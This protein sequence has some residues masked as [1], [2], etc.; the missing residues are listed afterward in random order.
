MIEM[1]RDTIAVIICFN[2]NHD[3]LRGLI[4]AISGSVGCVVLFNNGGLDPAKL[5]S[6]AAV[7]I[8]VESPGQNLGLATPLNFACEYGAKNGYRF[9]VSFDQDSTP[10]ADMIPLLERE[11]LTYQAKNPRA[12]AI[13]PRLV[14]VRDGKETISPFVRFGKVGVTKWIGEGTEPVSQ[15]ITSGCLL[16]L[17]MW[18]AE[19]RFNDALF[20]DFVDNN[21]CWR[22]TRK[23][24][25]ILGTSRTRMP[26]ELSEEIKESSYI[27]L[28]KYGQIRRYFQMRN[29]AY[30]LVHESLSLAQ[31][32]YVLRAMVVAFLSSMISD[33]QPLQS[34]WQCLRGLAHGLVGRLG[35][36]R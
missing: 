29:S 2:P 33:E 18:D 20:I 21:W 1:T 35:A 25:L 6:T 16:D 3:R 10:P 17:R 12:I 36:Y 7:R 23:Q 24:Y 28:N 27:S 13:G 30:H 5:A 14:D 11:L 34:V 19:N 15:L 26:H 4:D 31:R 32:L 8:H 9:L 22:M